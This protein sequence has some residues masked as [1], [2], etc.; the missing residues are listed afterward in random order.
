MSFKTFRIKSRQIGITYEQ[1][2]VNPDW[3]V[4]IIPKDEEDGNRAYRYDS[5]DGGNT[6]E[7]VP[8]SGE[9]FDRL[10]GENSC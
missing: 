7:R 6:P 2:I 1:S 8:Y 3:I 10:P 4:R 5:D 9:K